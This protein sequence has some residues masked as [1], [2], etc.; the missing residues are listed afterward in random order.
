[1][2]KNVVKINEE[3]IRNIISESVKNVIKEITEDKKNEFKKYFAYVCKTGMGAQ[4]MLNQVVKI[5]GFDAL[6]KLVKGI[7][8]EMEEYNPDNY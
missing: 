1:M 5:L 3:Q 4:A 2:K 7:Y 6:F 8:D